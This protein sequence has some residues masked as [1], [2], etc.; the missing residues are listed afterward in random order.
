VG[1]HETRPPGA[2]AR[3]RLLDEHLGPRVDVARRFVEDE[4]SPVQMARMAFRPYAPHDYSRVDKNVEFRSKALP[5]SLAGL[6]ET[7]RIGLQRDLRAARPQ[8]LVCADQAEK[9]AGDDG[10]SY[11][12]RLTSKAPPGIGRETGLEYSRSRGSQCNE[13]SCGA[14]MTIVSRP[15]A[16]TC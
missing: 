8:A 11:F 14:D 10:N 15:C 1:D 9:I 6:R 13:Q 3:H 4:A 12:H 7:L 2:E 16:W 5:K